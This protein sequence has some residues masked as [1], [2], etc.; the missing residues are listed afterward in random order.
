MSRPSIRD[1]LSLPL[2]AA[3]EDGDRLGK[4]L[5]LL[6]ALS[7][8]PTLFDPGTPLTWRAVYEDLS[9]MLDPLGREDA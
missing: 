4:N 3:L 1:D 7:R 2:F 6:A 9:S 5:T 8:S